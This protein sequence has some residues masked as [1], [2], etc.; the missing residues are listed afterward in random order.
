MMRFDEFKELIDAV[1]ELE[2]A[3][4][5][6]K[7]AH[8]ISSVYLYFNGYQ[9]RS[10]DIM[11]MT[12]EVAKAAIVNARKSKVEILADNLRAKNIDP[13]QILDKYK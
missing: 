10:Y 12:G 8:N 9:A 4:I 7:Q 5:Q 11:T 6:L 1:E 2:A 3:C 13:T